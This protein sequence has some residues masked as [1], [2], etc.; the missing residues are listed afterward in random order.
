MAD[1]RYK[2]AA[3]ASLRSDTMLAARYKGCP[4]RLRHQPFQV[5][6]DF[7]PVERFPLRAVCH[8][9]SL[10]V[11]AFDGHIPKQ[12]DEGTGVNKNQKLRP[13]FC[14]VHRMAPHAVRYDAPVF[15]RQL[16]KHDDRVR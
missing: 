5:L 15:F 2:H 3:L 8:T 10:Q 7:T 4:S 12:V 14:Q 13:Q 6:K 9:R 16:I 11:V 1:S